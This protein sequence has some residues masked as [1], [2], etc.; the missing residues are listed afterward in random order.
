[1]QRWPTLDGT[2]FIALCPN[3]SPATE[4]IEE[5]EIHDPPPSTEQNHEKDP[6]ARFR[7]L[8]LT[9]QK[10]AFPEDWTE[11]MLENLLEKA[12]EILSPKRPTS[13]LPSNEQ[14]SETMTEALRD[15]GY[16]IDQDA[17][18]VRI[19]GGPS[20][21]LDS[22]TVSPYDVIR[23]AADLEGGVL[24]LDERVHCLKCDAVIPPDK[25]SCQWCG[26]PAPPRKEAADQG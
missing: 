3:C 25:S 22:E 8:I 23:M 10:E 24:P 9:S 13:R 7:E 19:S 18:G 5:K 17:H 2:D 26:E 15:R 11:E 12:R 4:P 1:M 21:G 14:F 20:G 6:R 16:V